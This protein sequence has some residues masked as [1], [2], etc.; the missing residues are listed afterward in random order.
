MTE[1]QSCHLARVPNHAVFSRKDKVDFARRML[2][3][4]QVWAPVPTP[5]DSVPVPRAA[6]MPTCLYPAQLTLFLHEKRTLDLLVL[7]LV[8]SDAHL[9]CSSLRV[10]EKSLRFIALSKHMGSLGPPQLS[11]RINPFSLLV[12]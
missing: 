7:S 5:H 8:V 12:Q 10:Q 11:L 6:Q 9:F 4:Q 1:A 3:N 2:F